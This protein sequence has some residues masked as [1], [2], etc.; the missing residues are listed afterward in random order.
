MP[1]SSENSKRAW[2]RMLLLLGIAFV[3]GGFV[4]PN[5][6]ITW[7]EPES[8]ASMGSLNVSLGKPQTSLSPL[9]VYARAAQAVYRSVVYI[10]ASETVR[11]EPDIFDEMMGVEPQVEQSHWEGSGV[12][13]TPD[14]YILTNEHVVGRSDSGRKITVTLADGRRFKGHLV[15]ADY[16]TDVALVKIDG[17]NLP[18]A[19]LGT[20]RGLV[21]GQICVAIG[22]P[23]GLRFTVTNGVISAL[24]RPIATDD[25]RIYS[26]LIQ[27]SAAIN[28]GNSGGPLVDI[29]G[30][31]IGI[32]TLVRQHAEGI[33][34]AIPIDTAL[35]VAEELKA[36]GK[37]P[38][39]WLGVV[40]QTNT[41]SLATRFGLPPV[42]G[43]VVTGV[44][45][46]GPA[47][48]AGIEPGDVIT[49]I[50][51]RPITDSDQ[52]RAVTQGLKVG[53]TVTLEVH[54]GDQ[55]AQIQVQVAQQP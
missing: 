42:K 36:Y 2:L 5:I 7:H 26:H 49:R 54:R 32:N 29:E 8:Q 40:V 55:Y 24:D 52:F 39:P 20:V 46:D 15:G 17:H 14:G 37:V 44:Y 13:I 31:V 53:S 45:R 27:H 21:P 48:Q 6:H 28:P 3:L 19:K 4:L 47:A 51:G 10:D 18:A 35:Q 33:G 43:V 34:F 30:R 38:R 16:T 22:N 1:S 11:V 41:P 23:L 9:E 12:I 25:G 50:N